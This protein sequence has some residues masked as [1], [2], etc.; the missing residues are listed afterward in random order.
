MQEKKADLVVLG[1]GPGGYSAAFRAADLGRKVTLI[2][3]SPVLGGVCLNV[4]CIPSK[5]LLHLA[6][7][8]EDAEK[9]APLG[10]SFGKPT[11]DL[12]K[13][14]AHRDSVIGTLTGGL[15]SLCKARKVERIVG[16]GTFLSDTGLKVVTDKEELKL[17]FEDLIIAVGSRSVQIPGIPY[18]DERVWDS[19]K[20]L[21]LTHIPK[22]L[23]IIGGGIIGLEVATMY[24]ALGS[25]ITIIEMMDSLIPPADADLKQ[26][27]VRKLKKQYEA[28][29]TSTKVEKVEAKKEAL[30]LHLKGEKAPE[31]IEADAVLVAVG[32]KANSD[33]IALENTSIKTNTR[34]WIEVDKKL[35]T[36]V[37][38]VFAIGDVVGDPMLA[39][40]SSHQGKVAAEVASGH[41]SAFTP[42]GI[43]SVAYTSPEVAWIGLTEAEAKQ[44]GI[45]FKKGSFPWMANGRAL[46]AVCV[47]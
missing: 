31:T 24:H 6:E 30:V 38:H 10:V 22:R 9:L 20:A 27:L 17:T 4:G 32:R 16:T 37:A 28:I 47:A 45:A 15:D 2:E 33:G 34:G 21:E 25:R 8:I 36:N 12:E 5:T 13:I 35:R 26:P 46:S 18:E 44:K 23:A 14:R 40:K 43:P 39:H 3:K 29:Y 41:A 11:F 1:G 19:T 7:V 42:M